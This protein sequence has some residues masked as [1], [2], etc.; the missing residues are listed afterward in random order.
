MKVAV[1]LTSL[2]GIGDNAMYHRAITQATSAI[3]VFG[4]REKP[5]AITLPSKQ[6]SQ[7]ASASGPHSR[8]RNDVTLLPTRKRSDLL[9]WETT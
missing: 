9:P 8:K 4:R 2:K 1:R 7:E 5:G 6:Q 3:E